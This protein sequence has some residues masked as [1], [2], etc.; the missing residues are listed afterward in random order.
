MI[1]SDRYERHEELRAFLKGLRQRV[2]PEAR[3]L[4]AH[5]RLPS[6]R[7]RPVTQEEVAEAIGVS[8]AWYAL[9]E[10][11]ATI[12]TSMQLLDRLAGALMLTS[13]ERAILFYLAIPELRQIV[14]SFGPDFRMDRDAAS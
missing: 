13:R 1:A 8:R 6:R 3:T 9:L 11:G 10:S 7:G 5:Q 12:R 4:G 14:G 2:H